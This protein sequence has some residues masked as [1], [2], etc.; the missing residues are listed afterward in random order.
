MNE[1]T[2]KNFDSLPEYEKPPLAEVICGTTYKPLDKFVASHMG[3]LWGQFQPDYPKV[4]ELA[5][6]SSPIEIFQGQ[7]I[8]TELEFTTVPPLP[9]Q[10]FTSKDGNN[11]IQI[12]RDRFIFNWRKVNQDD[13]YPRYLKVIESFEE[14][15]S[16]FENFLQSGNINVEPIQ[17][18][19]T[20]I[21]QIPQGDLWETIQDIRNIFPKIDLSFN[22]LILK[23][24]ETTNWRISFVL[25]NNLGRLHTVI[26]TNAERVSDGK[27][28]IMFELTVRGM[29][30]E[31]S[32]LNRKAWFDSAREW[33]VKGFTDLTSEEIQ[34]KIWE[35]RK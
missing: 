10:R 4:E 5:P 17:N 8:P 30:Q 22:G 2:K 26:R 3:I 6:L 7:Q 20:Y 16:I 31:Q 9:R 25:P 32:K 29:N 15:L 23:E 21:N 35:R 11:V 33:I 19:L 1:I 27:P 28:L 18:E 14:K 34:N 13:S 24:P 12:Q